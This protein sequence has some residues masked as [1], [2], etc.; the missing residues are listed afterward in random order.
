MEY[1][2]KEKIVRFDIYCQ[3][4]KHFN[5]GPEQDPCYDCLGETVNTD[6]YKPVKWEEET[7]E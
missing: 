7:K 4:C 6:S 1:Q 3:T 5:K 2:S